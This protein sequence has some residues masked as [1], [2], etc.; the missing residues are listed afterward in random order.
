MNGKRILV[1]NQLVVAVP[2]DVKSK[3]GRLEL[4]IDEILEW[5]LQYRKT[6]DAVLRNNRLGNFLYFSMDT[7][8]GVNPENPNEFT[9]QAMMDYLSETGPEKKVA[10][11]MTALVYDEEL[12]GYRNCYYGEE[13]EQFQE[14]KAQ[15]LSMQEDEARMKIDQFQALLR[16]SEDSDEPSCSH[17]DEI[18]DERCPDE[19][20]VAMSQEDDPGEDE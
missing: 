13:E 10:G 17:C 5:L 2:D 12:G 4:T 6:S 3:D 7:P 16:Q 15:M 1:I 8:N 14:R 20:G 18:C 9:A 19:P 11:M